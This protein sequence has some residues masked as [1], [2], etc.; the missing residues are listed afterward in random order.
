MFFLPV[1]ETVYARY[2]AYFAQLFRFV[3]TTVHLQKIENV[4]FFYY[5]STGHKIT[6][7]SFVILGQIWALDNFFAIEILVVCVDLLNCLN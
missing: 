3:P 5:M 4:V 1:P 6:K 7:Y 2:S